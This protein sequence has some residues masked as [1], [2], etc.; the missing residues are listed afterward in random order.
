MKKYGSGPCL[1]QL[2]SCMH[3]HKQYETGHVHQ[4]TQIV[5]HPVC[6]CNAYS[7]FQSVADLGGGA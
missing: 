2:L 5:R 7:V 3:T 6:I 1:L 4:E